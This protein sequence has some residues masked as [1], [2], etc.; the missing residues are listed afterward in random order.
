MVYHA[1]KS[2]KIE[3][4]TEDSMTVVLETKELGQ[5]RSNDS[6]LD[7]ELSIGAGGLHIR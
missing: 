7:V 5:T 4:K 6:E 2:C 1:M 3:R